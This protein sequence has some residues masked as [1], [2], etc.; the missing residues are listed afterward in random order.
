LR[1]GSRLREDLF[2]RLRGEVIEVPP[3]RARPDDIRPLFDALLASASRELHLPLPEVQPAVYRVL[4][5]RAWPGNVR[6]L[7]NAVRRALLERPRRL[8][9]A[10]FADPG[11]RSAAERERSRQRVAAPGAPGLPT[12]RQA[13][14]DLER[15]LLEE[16]LRAERGNATRAAKLLGVSR[17]HMGTL[18]ERYAFDL[19]SFRSTGPT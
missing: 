16:A 4:E 11:E 12:L 19:D 14:Q 18:L 8:E 10:H 15:Q 13:R 6:E 1:T 3:L 5:A 2:F 7:E 17:R 9:A